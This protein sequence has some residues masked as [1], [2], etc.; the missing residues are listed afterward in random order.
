ML[1]GTYAKIVLK[2]CL[3]ACLVVLTDGCASK[4]NEEGVLTS[5]SKDV[6]K[7][8]LL[9]VNPVSPANNNAPYLIGIADE[10]TSVEVYTG[11]TCNGFLVAV[12]TA[13]KFA[14]SGIQVSVPDDSTTTFSVVGVSGGSRS[15]CSNSLT[16]VEDSTP[17]NVAVDQ[18]F[19][20]ADP[21]NA[22]PITFN[23]VFTKA[24]DAS[25]FTTADIAQ[26]GTATGITWSLSTTD[27]TNYTLTA[28][29]VSTDGTVVP[30][31]GAAVV[32]DPAGNFNT[33]STSS[34]NSVTYDNV[35]PTVTVTGP[36]NN[37]TN[38]PVSSFVHL[39]FSESLD[40]ST[41]TF[42]PSG[43]INLTNGGSNSSAALRL[44]PDGFDDCH[45]CNMMFAVIGSLDQ[46]SSFNLGYCSFHRAGLRVGIHNDFTAHMP[47][48]S[49]HGLNQ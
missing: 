13:E 33:A 45:R 9:S 20:Q 10:K 32:Q 31:I 8:Q 5:S 3:V 47:C 6:S 30:S 26:N 25:T 24:I 34:D 29:A 1:S 21:T 16:Y 37:S 22:L 43:N 4:F 49:A 40:Q 42:G 18:V 2:A 14:S 38:V 35:A 12:D 36:A 15:P 7:P 11:S 48:S 46:S 19:V 28:T 44:F 41:L 27:N 39:G 23:V 17:P